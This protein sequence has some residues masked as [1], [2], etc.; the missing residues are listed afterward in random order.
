MPCVIESRSPVARP[1]ENCCVARWIWCAWPGSCFIASMVRSTA[2]CARRCADWGFRWPTTWAANSTSWPGVALRFI[3]AEGD[4]GQQLL[5]EQ[6]GSVVRRLAA[7][8]KLGVR[9]IPGTDHTFTARWAHPVVLDAI[10]E[11]LDR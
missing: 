9:I 8:G 10:C 4:P 11:A 3:F 6:G 2:R 1:G 7:G 5:A